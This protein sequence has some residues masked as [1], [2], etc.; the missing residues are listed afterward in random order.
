MGEVKASV[1][2]PPAEDAIWS[3]LSALAGG[4]PLAEA[5]LDLARLLAQKHAAERAFVAQIGSAGEIL[6]AWGADLDGLPIAAPDRRIDAD[7]ARAALGREGPVYL[8]DVETSG[9][10]GSRLAV[11]SKEPEGAALCRALVVL[12]HRFA[13]FAFD[14]VTAGEAV[15]WG[16]LA[17]L[18]LRLGERG[19]L[20]RRDGGP[21]KGEADDD[22]DDET[23]GRA[24]PP[25]SPSSRIAPELTTVSP[26]IAATRSFPGILGQSAALKRALGRLDAAIDGDL[27]VLLVG[28]TGAGKEV[29]ARALHEVGRRA[30]RLLVTVNCG[31]IPDALFEAELFGHA[32]GSFTGADRARPGLFARADKG[33]LFLDEIGE[34]PLLRQAALLRALQERCFRP[35]GS[36]E[37]IP[38][39]VRIVAATN[40]DL[41]RAVA[42]GAFRK[43]LLY[44]LNAVEIRIPPLR[45][46]AED[47]PELARA[48]LARAGSSA[49]LAP[50][51]LAALGVYAWPGNVRELEHVM[52]R[53]ALLRAGAIDLAHLPRQIRGAWATSPANVGG[54]VR[55]DLRPRAPEDEREEVARAL[56]ANGGN[57]SRAAVSLGLSRQGLKKRMVRLG[58]RAPAAA[59]GEGSPAEESEVKG[60]REGAEKEVS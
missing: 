55:A 60:P 34:L 56:A 32:R 39:D 42:E 53:L 11:A 49:R 5:A 4:A 28:E 16:T 18:V 24:P 1:P 58:M 29:F 20:A 57:I 30:G 9:G 52:Q 59:G 45:E 43:D 12:E 26:V 19:S 14:R 31:A 51:V 50:A 33:T 48:F 6:A 15:R 47:I 46:R 23:Q 22:E 54:R 41:E 44:R 2:S 27:P 36:D 3:W 25:P 7:L 13:A 8:G 10:R 35:V 17:G 38:L 40:K 37:E 21:G